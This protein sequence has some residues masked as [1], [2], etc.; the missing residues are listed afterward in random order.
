M[1]KNNMQVMPSQAA[2][3]AAAQA[4]AEE[5]KPEAKAGHATDKAPGH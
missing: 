5:V 4:K 2:S 1:L 3:E